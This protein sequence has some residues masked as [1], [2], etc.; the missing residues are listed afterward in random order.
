MIRYRCNYCGVCFDTP[1]SVEYTDHIDEGISVNYRER[2][3]P[4]CGCESFEEVGTCEKCG[5]VAEKDHILCHTCK[6]DL[7]KRICDFMD[8]LTE[9]EE[10]QLD[11]WLDGDFVTNRRNWK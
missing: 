1:V 8:T 6:R 10:R 7:K 5:G 3:C 2:R 11:D 9:A 4:I